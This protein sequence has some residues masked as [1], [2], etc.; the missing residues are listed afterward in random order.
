[1]NETVP[2]KVAENL[3]SDISSILVTDE[4]VLNSNN[5]SEVKPLS[6]KDSMK[7]DAGVKKRGKKKKKKKFHGIVEPVHGESNEIQSVPDQLSDATDNS[8]ST[9]ANEVQGV[10]RPQYPCSLC[11]YVASSEI[12]LMYHEGERHSRKRGCLDPS[13]GVW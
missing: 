3:D 6:A 2:T 12:R 9:K 1:M 8:E 5:T 13:I 10:S 4:S 7:G 11:R